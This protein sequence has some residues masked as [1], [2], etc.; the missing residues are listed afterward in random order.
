LALQ[1]KP[2]VI[3]HLTLRLLAIKE[4][5]ENPKSFTHDIIKDVSRKFRFGVKQKSQ[6]LSPEFSTFD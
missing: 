6:T 2:L 1:D 4:Y 5:Y 3:K